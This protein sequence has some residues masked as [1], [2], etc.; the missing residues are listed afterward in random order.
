MWQNLCTSLINIF[1]NNFT[2]LINWFIKIYLF[3]VKYIRISICI[4]YQ[5]RRNKI[6]FFYKTNTFVT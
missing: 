4:N 2:Y 3:K 1:S 5:S 6:K